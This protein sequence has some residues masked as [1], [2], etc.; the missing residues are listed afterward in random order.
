MEKKEKKKAIFREVIRK[1]MDDKRSIRKYI[2]ENRT[3]KG[4]NSESV[5][6][7]KPL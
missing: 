1:M 4:Y 3:I 2:K 6:F 7:A 5:Q